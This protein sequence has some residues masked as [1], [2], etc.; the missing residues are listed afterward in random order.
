MC[1]Y[2]VQPGTYSQAQVPK[3]QNQGIDDDDEKGEGVMESSEYEAKS[4]RFPL[5]SSP[6][7]DDGH[8]G[9]RMKGGDGTTRIKYAQE[10]PGNLQKDLFFAPWQISGLA[11]I[12]DL[13]SLSDNKTTKLM[14]HLA[15]GLSKRR[16]MRFPIVGITQKSMLDYES[17][18]W[19][20]DWCVWVNALLFDPLDHE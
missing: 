7:H 20:C 3:G 4:G 18:K 8:T 14:E 17:R 6:W 1:M 9:Y 11:R 5:D 16:P 12:S 2:I 13:L 10:V 19:F 15:S